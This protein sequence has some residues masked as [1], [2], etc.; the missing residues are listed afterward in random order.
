MR[1]EDEGVE[2]HAVAELLHPRKEFSRANLFVE[3]TERAPRFARGVSSGGLHASF[4][5]EHANATGG[6]GLDESPH[7]CADT[8]GDEELLVRG[9]DKT[10]ERLDALAEDVLPRGKRAELRRA[11]GVPR[12]ERRV[13]WRVHVEERRR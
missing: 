8:S 10:H 11:L 5:R 6:L 2:E 9:R 12:E 1:E 3:E 7:R 4:L 13:G